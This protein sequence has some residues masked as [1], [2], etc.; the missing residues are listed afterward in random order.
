MPER[1]A[2]SL[3]LSKDV[4]DAVTCVTNVRADKSWHAARWLRRVAAEPEDAASV[5]DNESSRVCET[6][7]SLPGA[8]GPNQS[9]ALYC[10]SKRSGRTVECVADRSVADQISSL[11][12][13]RPLFLGRPLFIGPCYAAVIFFPS[14]SVRS[15]TMF[16]SGAPSQT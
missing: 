3:S 4:G 1:L 13:P 7:V 16:S 14:Y 15:R 5:P 11:M 6:H 12:H 2:L 10:T 8:R 9:V